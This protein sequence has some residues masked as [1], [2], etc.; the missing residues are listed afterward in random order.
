MLS[1]QINE[2]IKQAMLKKEKEKLDALRGLKALFIENKTS[3]APIAEMDVLIN[4][5]KKLKGSL[6]NFPEGHNLRIKTEQEI[7]I[8]SHYMPKQLS[9][10]EVKAI[11]SDIIKNNPGANQGIIMKD[12]TPKIKGQFDGKAASELVKSMLS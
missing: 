1:D 6:E 2:D 11:I 12:L 4:C 10:D 5:V 7:E 8:L 9:A 3:K